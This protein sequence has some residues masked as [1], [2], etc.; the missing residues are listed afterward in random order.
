M[1]FRADRSH[2]IR[3]KRRRRFVSRGGSCALPST[4]PGEGLNERLIASRGIGK[5]AAPR[6]PYGLG[7]GKK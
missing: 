7:I 4:V 3:N 1:R 2:A 5:P 6:V